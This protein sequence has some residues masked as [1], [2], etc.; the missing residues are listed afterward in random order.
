MHYPMTGRGKMQVVK[1]P[2]LGHYPIAL[3][4]GQF[5]DH[6]QD[7]SSEQLRYL[8]LNTALKAPPT[9]ERLCQIGMPKADLAAGGKRAKSGGGGGG[10]NAKRQHS[11]G[12]D[13]ESD[14]SSSDS[15]SGSDSSSSDSDSEDETDGKA[16]NKP[17]AVKAEAAADNK[18]RIP[19]DAIIQGATCKM[20]AGDRK[21]N[22]RTHKAEKLIRCS[23]CENSMHPT[24]A[25]LSLEL[26]SVSHFWRIFPYSKQQEY[27]PFQGVG[28]G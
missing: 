6:Y 24:C 8:P 21:R 7:L 22:L 9:N 25:G 1:K 20:C 26:L 28:Y 17:E 23:K 3:I 2:K 10:P 14:S 19:V 4:P 13:S 12:S 15:S 11:D 5:T 27:S 16:D 18:P